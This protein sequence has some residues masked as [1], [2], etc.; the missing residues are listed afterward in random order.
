M[1]GF[2]FE[3]TPLGELIVIRPKVFP[4]HISFKEKAI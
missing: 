4:S 1:L 2:E 3:G